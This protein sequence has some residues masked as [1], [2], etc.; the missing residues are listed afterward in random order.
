MKVSDD[1]KALTK[2]QDKIDKLKIIIEIDKYKKE[3]V[4]R[5]N[6]YFYL[7]KYIY[8]NGKKRKLNF[9]IKQLMCGHVQ[10]LKNEIQLKKIN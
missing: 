1:T 2:V 9:I 4:K 8:I 6:K 5:K 10:I 3:Y 7:N